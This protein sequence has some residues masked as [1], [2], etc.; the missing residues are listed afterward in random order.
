MGKVMSRMNR[1]WYR[2]NAENRAQRVISEEKPVVAPRHPSSLKG[3]EQ[4]LSDESYDKEK[5]MNKDVVLNE[6]LKKVFVVS[7]DPVVDQRF[8]KPSEQVRLPTERSTPDSTELGYIEPINVPKGKVTLK[9]LMEL[10]AQHREHPE[11]YNVERISDQYRISTENAKNILE[12]LGVFN[13]YM[14]EQTPT[15]STSAKILGYFQPSKS[16][17]KAL[18]DK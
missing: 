9:Q 14:K 12:Y 8:K 1:Y 2:F 16:N 11:V 17:T 6:Y 5:A 10:L 18:D 7:H 15:L 13:I 4:I 3:I